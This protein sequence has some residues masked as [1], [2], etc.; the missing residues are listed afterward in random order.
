[1]A[2]G[3]RIIVED[4]G[5]AWLIGW[6]RKKFAA[7]KKITGLV[8]RRYEFAGGESVW[9]KGGPGGDKIILNAESGEWW[10]AWVF[11]EGT[12]M[13][14]TFADINIT[15]ERCRIVSPFKWL[16]D[17]WNKRYIFYEQGEPTPYS[18]TIKDMGGDR[19]LI[20]VFPY[21]EEI[22]AEFDPEDAIVEARVYVHDRKTPD[23]LYR[24]HWDPAA[25]NRLDYDEDALALASTEAVFPN[26]IVR[27]GAVGT[28]VFQSM[29]VTSTDM[30]AVRIYTIEVPPTSELTSCVTGVDE[31]NRKLIDTSVKNFLA[32]S[33]QV[34]DFM[35]QAELPDLPYSINAAFLG[36]LPDVPSAENGEKYKALFSFSKLRGNLSGT[37]GFFVI[38]GDGTISEQTTVVPSSFSTTYSGRAVE[39]GA[40]P[41]PEPH[42]V[43]PAPGY[44]GGSARC[45]CYFPGDEGVKIFC[46]SPTE[47]AVEYIKEVPIGAPDGTAEVEY[48]I[49]KTEYKTAVYEFDLQGAYQG[50]ADEGTMCS[51]ADTQ[52]QQ[53]GWLLDVTYI[54]PPQSAMITFGLGNRRDATTLYHARAPVEYMGNGCL[55]AVGLRGFLTTNDTGVPD[56][57]AESPTAR[58][59]SIACVARSFDMGQTWTYDTITLDFGSSPTP[60]NAYIGM[61]LL[62]IKKFVADDAGSQG[63]LALVFEDVVEEALYPG[64]KTLTVITSSDVGRTWARSPTIADRE[65]DTV[66]ALGVASPAGTAFIHTRTNSEGASM[67][68]DNFFF[69]RPKKPWPKCS[70]PF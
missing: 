11:V 49:T 64:V 67:N 47:T 20:S 23:Q 56:P 39:D 51:E 26:S 63:V 46:A 65:D 69:S 31:D 52:F 45:F 55:V 37:T 27:I 33:W 35:E 29:S 62:V 10:A 8:N 58:F 12:G 25:M 18:V 61:R 7:L 1:M 17:L 44:G 9:M 21:G 28:I 60:T 70:L 68:L 2:L 19:S 66:F 13:F 16:N 30:S 54:D 15:V 38:D 36:R 50:L 32:S 40:N 41:D 24:I 4:M 57:G 22:Y 48:S 59:D 5:A 3:P 6:A 42:Y 43:F 53:N 34:A 14:E